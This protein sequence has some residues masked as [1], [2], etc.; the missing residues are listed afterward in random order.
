MLLCNGLD[1]PQ[2]LKGGVF[3]ISLAIQ[4]AQSGGVVVA[5]AAFGGNLGRFELAGE[6]ASG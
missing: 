1:E 3:E 4:A 2:S 5:V 6:K